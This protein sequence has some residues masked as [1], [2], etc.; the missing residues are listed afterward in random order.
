MR[1]VTSAERVWNHAATRYTKIIINTLLM[2]TWWHHSSK[3]NAVKCTLM[4]LTTQSGSGGIA[5]F[6]GQEDHQA[7]LQAWPRIQP[8]RLS[9]SRW[10]SEWDLNPRPRDG[11]SDALTTQPRCLHSLKNVDI[12]LQ[13]PSYQTV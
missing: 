9:K 2:L 1:E 13:V 12:S 3:L 11:K 10:L 4:V 7:C 5:L 6:L 8:S